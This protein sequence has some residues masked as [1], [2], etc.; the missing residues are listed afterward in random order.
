MGWKSIR[1]IRPPCRLA[2]ECLIYA[3][4]ALTNPVLPAECTAA[5]CLSVAHSARWWRAG[6]SASESISPRVDLTSTNYWYKLVDG[7]LLEWN[8]LRHFYPVSHNS[9]G[10]K[11]AGCTQEYLLKNA[12]P[13]FLLSLPHFPAS[14]CWDTPQT[15]YLSSESTSGNTQSNPP[16]VPSFRLHKELL[17]LFIHPHSIMGT[18]STAISTWGLLT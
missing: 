8:N 13:G 6:R 16:K 5:L 12:L 17:Q 9:L 1:R 15:G 10:G 4:L 2:C 18:I 7:Y 11:C 3:P 14:V